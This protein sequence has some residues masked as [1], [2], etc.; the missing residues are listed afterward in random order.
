[1]SLRWTARLP[2]T[3]HRK[4]IP[5]CLLHERLPEV[6]LPSFVHTWMPEEATQLFMEN[7]GKSVNHATHVRPS[8]LQVAPIHY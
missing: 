4:S 6:L 1:M 3:L 7:I 8:Y 2:L 5:S